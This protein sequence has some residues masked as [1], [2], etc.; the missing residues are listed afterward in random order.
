MRALASSRALLRA[1]RPHGDPVTS[2][3]V[4]SPGFT[5]V[6]VLVALLILSIL[7]VMGWRG[8][9]SMAMAR[10]IS[11]AAAERA[12]LMSAVIGQWEQ[13]LQAVHETPSVPGLTFDGASLRLT[14]RA[15]GGIQLVVW[16]LREGVWRRWAAPP[17]T[18]AADL[19]E[20]WMRSQQLQGLEPQQ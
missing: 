17:S 15:A 19:Q 10:D 2:R 12:L 9:D 1:R 4:P 14:R 6:E 13:D 3:A 11:Q 20:A 8:I 16:S 18:R 5:L 7:A